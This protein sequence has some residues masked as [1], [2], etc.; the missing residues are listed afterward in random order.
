MKMAVSKTVHRSSNTNQSCVQRSQNPLN[1]EKVYYVVFKFLDL[2]QY[3][4]IINI[5]NWAVVQW[6]IDAHMET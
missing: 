6:D 5:N 3:S 4:Y 2:R 1:F